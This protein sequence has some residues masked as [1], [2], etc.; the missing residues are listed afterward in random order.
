MLRTNRTRLSAIKYLEKGYQETLKQQE[1]WWKR[2][3]STF[4]G[5]RSRFIPSR[6]KKAWLKQ[7]CL[8]IMISKEKKKRGST[9][10]SPALMTT[11]TSTTQ[12]KRSSS[13]MLCLP[14]LQIR[15]SMLTEE[16]SI[17]WSLMLRS[18][19]RSTKRLRMWN[20]WK[21]LCT[22]FTERTSHSWRSSSHG[23]SDI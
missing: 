5:S 22:L 7:E 3:R 10:P 13:L 6:P 21:G 12:W 9:W 18:Q 4:H 19:A 15:A 11:S 14:A 17:S 1:R 16:W 20:W 8:W 23:H 2:T